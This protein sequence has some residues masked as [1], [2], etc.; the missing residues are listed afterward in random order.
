MVLVVLRC[1]EKGKLGF[2]LVSTCAAVPITESSYQYTAIF[3]MLM[4]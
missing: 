1:R 2:S 4:D 3:V